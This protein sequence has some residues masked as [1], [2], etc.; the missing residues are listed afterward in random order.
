MY[1]YI[2]RCIVNL[3]KINIAFIKF[4]VIRKFYLCI[5]GLGLLNL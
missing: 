5:M 2:G 4:I 3:I 1:L